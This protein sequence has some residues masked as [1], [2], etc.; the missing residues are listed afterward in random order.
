MLMSQDI[1]FTPL[2]SLSEKLLQAS[3]TLRAKD[4]LVNLTFIQMMAINKEYELENDQV[5]TVTQCWTRADD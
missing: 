5:D 2:I 4:T 1:F 3:G